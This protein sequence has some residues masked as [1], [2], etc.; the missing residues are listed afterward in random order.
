M[1]MPKLSGYDVCRRVKNDVRFRHTKVLL[2]IDPFE[3]YSEEEA[4]RAGA[5]GVLMKPFQSLRKLVSTVRA[6]LDSRSPAPGPKG[7]NK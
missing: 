4:R 6:A 5:D 7:E 3:P 2:L 1:H